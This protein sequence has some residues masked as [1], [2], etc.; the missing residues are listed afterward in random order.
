V[1][2]VVIANASLDIAFHDK[3][4]FLC[5]VTISFNSCLCFFLYPYCELNISTKKWTNN[6]Y[7]H[8]C[9]FSL[10]PNDSNNNKIKKDSDNNAC[11]EN[12]LGL[13]E[14]PISKWPMSNNDWRIKIDVYHKD[15]LSRG[16]KVIGQKTTVGVNHPQNAI[17][18]LNYWVGIMD[19]IGR[20]HGHVV[21]INNINKLLYCL[22][23]LIWLL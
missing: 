20:I 2:G 22:S 3:V 16:I 21:K 11:W 23:M 13:K 6:N 15:F 8:S 4:S 5:L 9:L 12:K 10:K 19:G 17:N 1:S 14:S 7:I 18:M